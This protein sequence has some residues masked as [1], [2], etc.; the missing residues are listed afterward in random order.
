MKPIIFS[1][2]TGMGLFLVIAPDAAG[3]LWFFPDYALP[4]S[5]GPPA[6]W[7]AGTYGRGLNDATGK[8]DA[9]GAAVGRTS[10]RTSFM[11]AFGYI[12]EE[13]G[14]YTAGGAVAYDLITRGGTQASIQVGVGWLDL[15]FLD[16]EVTFL[17]FPIGFAVKTPIQSGSFTL[18]PW[19]MPRVN[20]VRASG[21]GESETETDLGVSGGFW[22]NTVSGFG[23]HTAID[24]L[25]VDGETP[26]Q[27]GVGIHFV[28]GQG[29]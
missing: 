24:G 29:G 9:F 15:D 10:R 7:V 19:F 11:G 2:F 25:F 27:L 21:A 20:I 1:L 4:S 13:G 23:F 17:S 28:L 14:E 5:D 3:Q 12:D 16:E 26:W 6:T 18:T 8:T 22:V